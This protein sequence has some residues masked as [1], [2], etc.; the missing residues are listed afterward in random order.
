M[1]LVGARAAALAWPTAPIKKGPL[2]Y[3]LKLSHFLT[4]APTMRPGP[5]QELHQI[6]GAQLRNLPGAKRRA[7]ATKHKRGANR[8]RTHGMC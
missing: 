4:H 6:E 3:G 1:P 5:H 7:E 2:F 8:P